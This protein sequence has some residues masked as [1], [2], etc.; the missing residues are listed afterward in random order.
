ME[1][2]LIQL[3]QLDTQLARANQLGFDLQSL[4]NDIASITEIPKTG[5]KP[6]YTQLLIEADAKLDNARERANEFHTY[7]YTTDSVDT[8]S[9]A[10]KLYE[11]ALTE[12]RAIIELTKF[13]FL[14]QK[15]LLSSEKT[16][17]QPRG[18]NPLDDEFNQYRRVGPLPESS[19]LREIR[20]ME[21]EEAKKR[22]AEQLEDVD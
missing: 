13:S 11:D 17:V 4:K 19:Y 18:Y 6:D 8:T 5:L 10:Y 14:T 12:C 21:L 15:L 1:R 3:L 16:Y 22:E 2:V 20:E 7:C 9:N